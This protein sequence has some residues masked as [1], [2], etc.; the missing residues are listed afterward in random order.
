MEFFKTFTI[1]TLSHLNTVRLNSECIHTE[2]A[3]DEKKNLMNC[4]NKSNS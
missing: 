3:K 1:Y 2:D 4:F